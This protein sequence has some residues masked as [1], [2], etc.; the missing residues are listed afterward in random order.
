MPGYWVRQWSRS[1]LGYF[2]QDTVDVS[3]GAI[4][5]RGH[6][7]NVSA[8]SYVYL[9]VHK[10]EGSLSTSSVMSEG[11]LCLRISPIEWRI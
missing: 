3:L 2:I 1:F 9:L 4:A 5:S 10:S 8:T 11:D 6:A 7:P